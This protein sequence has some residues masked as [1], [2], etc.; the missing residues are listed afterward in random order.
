MLKTII[1][2]L[3]I[4]AAEPS[5]ADDAYRSFKSG[6]LISS[7]EPDTIA[8]GL[9]T[10]L[11]ER[12]FRIIKEKVDNIYTADDDTIIECM[13]LIWERMKII[14]EP[15]SAVTLATIKLNPEVFRAKKV[16]VILSGG[17]VDL[18]S[19]PF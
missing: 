18:G 7:H 2:V 10:T 9:L 11:S 6:E 4:F 8:D 13:R 16:G 3:K 12:T 15:S 5:G 14:V 17:N 1:R 19:L